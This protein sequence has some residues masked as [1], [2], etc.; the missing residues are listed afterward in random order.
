MAGATRLEGEEDLTA[1][2]LSSERV[3]NS[4]RAQGREM[5]QTVKDACKFDPK[6]ID[7]ALSDQIETPTWRSEKIC[8]FKRH[9]HND[10]GHEKRSAARAQ[11]R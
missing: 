4:N 1:I 10:D 2:L 9:L 7:Y 3:W 6:A 5:P 8:N 11:P